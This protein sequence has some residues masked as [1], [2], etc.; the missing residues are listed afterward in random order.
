MIMF[1]LLIAIPYMAYKFIPSLRNKIEYMR[2]DYNTFRSGEVRN[3]SD[4]VRLL[5]M[6]GGFEIA[7]SNF[8]VGVGAGDLKTEMNKF[9]IAQYPQLDEADHKL[10]HNQLIWVLTTTGIIGLALFLFS[11]FFPLLVNGNY[12]YWLFVVFHLILFSSFFTE[13]TLEE[14]YGPGFYLPF[15]FVLLIKSGL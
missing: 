13:A 3:L 9:Y 10:P 6:Q 12:K 1:F 8:W 14:Q 7:K 11:F 2:Y 5:T 15:L 4:G